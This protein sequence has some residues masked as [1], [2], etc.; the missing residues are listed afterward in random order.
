MEFKEV[1]KNR[2]SCKKIQRQAGRERKTDR[3][4]GSRE[5]GPDGKE[6]AGTACLRGAGGTDVS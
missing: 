2:Y 5:T 1:V 6:P 3:D 4:S